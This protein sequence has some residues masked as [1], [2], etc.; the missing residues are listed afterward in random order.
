MARLIR[1]RL[2]ESRRNTDTDSPP[3]RLHPTV[4]IKRPQA[5]APGRVR[6]RS[7]RCASAVFDRCVIV[8]EE[9]KWQE[10]IPISGKGEK[11][12][13]RGNKRQKNTMA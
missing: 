4:E 12:N 5:R 2:C 10:S 1:G 7:G 9:R 3:I 6:R 13:T 8:S 11:S